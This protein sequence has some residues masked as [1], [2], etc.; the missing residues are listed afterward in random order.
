MYV[1]LTDKLSSEPSRLWYC[2]GLSSGILGFEPLSQQL[3]AL[4]HWRPMWGHL[5]QCNCKCLY[6]TVWG[7]S[8]CVRVDSWLPKGGLEYLCGGSQSWYLLGGQNPTVLAVVFKEEGGGACAALSRCS[9]IAAMVVPYWTFKREIWFEHGSQ[10]PALVVQTSF[11]TAGLGLHQ[12]SYPLIWTLGLKHWAKQKFS[13]YKFQGMQGTTTSE[14]GNKE[15]VRKLGIWEHENWP[16][17]ENGKMEKMKF[18]IWNKVILKFET[19]NLYPPPLG[20]PIT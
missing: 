15:Y 17:W 6:R 4:L 5:V 3:V 19:G 12:K 2:F 9:T 13:V 20:G 8:V 7:C 18:G 10:Q 14:I 16:I 11:W 1:A